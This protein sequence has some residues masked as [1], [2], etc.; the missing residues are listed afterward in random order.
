MI[1][2]E[3]EN[4]EEELKMFSQLHSAVEEWLCQ[5]ELNECMDCMECWS[6]KD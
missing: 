1:K 3:N 4:W 5:R 6:D 2:E